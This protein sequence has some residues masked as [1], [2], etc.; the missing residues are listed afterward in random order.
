MAK[1]TLNCGSPAIQNEIL[2]LLANK[3]IR[4]IANFICGKHFAILADETRAVENKEQLVIVLRW[5]DDNLKVS[6][7]FIS[8]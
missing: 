6:E 1:K 4:K 5:V 8:L 7:D 2:Q 3:I